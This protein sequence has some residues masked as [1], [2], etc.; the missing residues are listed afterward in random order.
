MGSAPELVAG[1]LQGL[2]GVLLVLARQRELP[3]QVLD[4]VAGLV[5]GRALVLE[6]GVNLL[7]LLASEPLGLFE[8]VLEASPLLVGAARMP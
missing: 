6:L 8:Q 2:V 5:L 1:L 4:L 7:Q 3:L